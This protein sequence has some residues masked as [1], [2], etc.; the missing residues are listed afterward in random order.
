LHGAC[1]ELRRE[2]FSLVLAGAIAD[3]DRGAGGCEL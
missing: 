2:C 3:H 1:A